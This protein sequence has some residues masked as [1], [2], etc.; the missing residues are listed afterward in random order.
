MKMSGPL[1]YSF[2][3]LKTRNNAS[4]ILTGIFS[5]KLENCELS[6]NLGLEFVTHDINRYKGVGIKQQ[7]FFFLV[8]LPFPTGVSAY[9]KTV[10]AGF[11]FDAHASLFHTRIAC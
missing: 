4:R 10:W 5:K 3:K 11:T 8:L 6:Q 9:F 1:K 7:H 2:E